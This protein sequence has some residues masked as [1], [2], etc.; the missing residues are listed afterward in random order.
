MEKNTNY[1]M[2]KE[3]GG[4]CCKETGCMYVVDD[5]KPFNFRTIKSALDSGKVSLGSQPIQ[6]RAHQW[7][8]ILF[9]RA[10]NKNGDIIDLVSKG[11]PCMMLDENGCTYSEEE[12]PSLG[13]AIKPTKLGGPCGIQGGEQYMMEWINNYSQLQNFV[14]KY[15]NKDVYD[16]F[17]EELNERLDTINT[18]KE[19]DVEL[20]P[21]E[22]I[23]EGWY[24]KVIK[25]KEFIPAQKVKT[26]LNR[27]Y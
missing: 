7:S 23:I 11:G 16:L 20:T 3:C 10:R 21:M 19:L 24:N 5:F 15:T 25:N 6:F 9:L 12:R 4:A 22:S 2:C 27:R 8:I 18:K 17:M 1:D 26:A 13:L 14:T